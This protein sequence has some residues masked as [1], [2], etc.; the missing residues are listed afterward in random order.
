MTDDAA[1]KLVRWIGSSRAD[2]RAFPEAVRNRIGGAL[3]E[4]QL[5]RKAPYAKPLKGFAGAGVLSA[6]SGLKRTTG[7]GKSSK[8]ARRPDPGRGEQRQC[9]CRSRRCQSR[10]RASES[11]TR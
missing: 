8:K 10:G 1:P 5:G 3:W 9:I 2:I 6:S 7:N 4:A 11:A